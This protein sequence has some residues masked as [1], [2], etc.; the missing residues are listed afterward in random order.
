MNDNLSEIQKC[1]LETLKSF[2]VFCKKNNIKYFVAYGSLLGAVR[3]HGFIPWDDDIDVWMLRKDYD[4][5]ISLKKNVESGY[6]IADYHDDGYPYNFAKYYDNSK[7]FWEYSQFPFVIGPFVDVFP[8]DYYDSSSEEYSKLY[9]DYHTACWNYRKSVARHSWSE[10]F[11]DF[12][13]VNGFDGPIKL[14]KK[15][16]YRPRKRIFFKQLLQFDKIFS[17]KDAKEIKAYSDIKRLTFRKEWFLSVIEMPFENMTIPVP[18]GYDNLL[19]MN[20]GDYMTPPPVKNRTG[21]PAYYLNLEK[22]V[23]VEEILKE[24][25]K[26]LKPRKKMKLSVLVDEIKHRRGFW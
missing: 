5:F 22:R 12:A 24:K 14:V 2:D 20:Y 15:L 23:P 9:D 7:T 4:R 11:K 16:F 1:L 18:V 21:H 25:A 26:E 10:I 6:Q 13:L 19:R 17:E 8:L 3:H